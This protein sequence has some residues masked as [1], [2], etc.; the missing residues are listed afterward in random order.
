MTTSRTTRTTIAIASPTAPEP[1]A[2][3]EHPPSGSSSPSSSP[4]GFSYVDPPSN[5]TRGG[6][7][8]EDN[9]FNDDQDGGS[10]RDANLTDGDPS[11]IG[12]GSVFGPPDLADLILLN[13]LKC[14]VPTQVTTKGGGAKETCACGQL[15]SECKRHAGH[16]A[17]GRYR[18][19]EG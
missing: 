10:D 12:G 9:C 8:R 7:A 16:R 4:D 2:D 18:H 1:V 5:G 3:G 15:T 19:V 11:S 17:L 13:H 14:R 6:P